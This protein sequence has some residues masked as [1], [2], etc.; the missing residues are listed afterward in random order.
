[1][2]TWASVITTPQSLSLVATIRPGSTRISFCARAQCMDFGAISLRY[3]R[4]APSYTKFT[5]PMVRQMHGRTNASWRSSTGSAA[6]CS[7]LS[8]TWQWEPSSPS[9]DMKEPSPSTNRI[10]SKSVATDW[11]EHWQLFALCGVR[12]SGQMRISP[13]LPRGRPR[14]EMEVLRKRFRA[15]ETSDAIDLWWIRTRFHP[16]HVMGVATELQHGTTSVY[17]SGFRVPETSRAIE[18]WSG[19]SPCCGK[20]W[21]A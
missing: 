6:C 9:W 18:C 7:T 13:A 21:L 5:G 8:A 20:W 19:F 1:M 2:F 16:C 17:K 10:K 15:K 4:S 11:V 12:G 3:S 14:L